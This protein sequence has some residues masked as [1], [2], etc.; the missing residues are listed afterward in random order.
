MCNSNF[1]DS[2]NKSNSSWLWQGI[3]KCKDLVLKGA[4][5]IIG[6]NNEVYVWKDPWIRKLKGFTPRERE[7]SPPEIIIVAQLIDPSSWE[8]N[9]D[10]L[11]SLFDQ[12]SV[13]AILSIHIPNASTDDKLIW[14]P[15][16]SGQFSV[17]FAYITN[18]FQR[19]SSYTGNSTDEWNSF[20]NTKIHER[21]KVFL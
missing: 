7:T 6:N 16:Q 19:L 8:W 21:H 12:Q 5:F 17:K 1:L 3:L 2:K 11:H 13:E 15:N 20:W 10:L 4:C 18:Q 9:V 14:C